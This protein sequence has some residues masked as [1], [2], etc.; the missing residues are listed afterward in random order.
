M[1]ENLKEGLKNAIN[2]IIGADTVDEEVVS[3]FVKDIQRAL[4]QADVNVRLVLDVSERIRK[5]AL[6]EKPPA[7][8]SRKDQIIKIL[9]EELSSMLGEEKKF[10]LSRGKTNTIMM[11]GVQGSGK[12]STVAKLARYLT[13]KNYKVGVIAADTFRPGAVA[14]LKTLCELVGVDIYSD[15]K[16]KDPVKISR[17]GKKY[18]DG[19]KDVIIIDTAGR[20]KEERSL[21]EEMEAIAREV[22]P[23]LN[24][25][26]VDGTIGQQCYS[27]ALAFHQAFPVGGIIVTK[28]D[29]ASKGGGA[30]AAVAATG[31]KILFVTNGERIDDIEEFSPTRFVGRL[32]GL[33][34]IKALLEMIRQSEVEV[35]EKT[36]KRMMTGKI[37]MNDLLYQLEQTTKIGSLK[38]LLE[39]IPGL[40]GAIKEND[41]QKVEEKIPVYRS[42]I[43]SMTR[44]EREAPEIINSSRIKRIALGS[45]RSER[46]VRE[47]LARY[48]QMKTF[49]KMNRSRE[50]RQM[51]RR[52]GKGVNE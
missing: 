2:K 17:E 50:L 20:H 41:L 52:M 19:K 18:F 28:L 33:G 32:L 39:H 29:G 25:L 34:D 36:V 24:I 11:V 45:G 6:D 22:K 15:E 10:E 8:I 21:L 5:R 14:Q 27:Q 16:E 26:V 47:L 13:K 44:E 48:K 38:K 3:G 42:I 49:M 51:L 40:S 35:D 30:L 31:A 4:I 9:Y 12:T 7:G 37:T 1:L 23:D 43:Q 46:D